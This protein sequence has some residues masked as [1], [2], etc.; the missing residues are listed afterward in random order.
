MSVRRSFSLF[1]EGPLGEWM[2]DDLGSILH[3]LL[4]NRIPRLRLNGL[5]ILLKLEDQEDDA[6]HY[7]R[8]AFLC[9]IRDSL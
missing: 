2:D 9:I 4:S 8:S 6:E 5:S 1:I 7:G 3:R